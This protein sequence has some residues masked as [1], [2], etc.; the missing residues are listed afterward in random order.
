M[1]HCHQQIVSMISRH[2]DIARKTTGALV[3]HSIIIIYIALSLKNIN[4]QRTGRGRRKLFQVRVDVNS[5][6]SRPSPSFTRLGHRLARLCEFRQQVHILASLYCLVVLFYS[7]YIVRCVQ[8]KPE[9]RIPL[10]NI[11]EHPVFTVQMVN[12]EI[13]QWLNGQQCS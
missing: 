3:K 8:F 1:I 9:D 11:L 13:S 6:N 10:L 2:T 4:T 7:F 5:E 12:Q